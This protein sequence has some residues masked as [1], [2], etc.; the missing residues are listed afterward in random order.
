M[1]FMRLP[2]Q[3]G[4]LYVYLGLE[5]GRLFFPVRQRMTYEMGL[6]FPRSVSIALGKPESVTLLFVANGHIWG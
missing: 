6:P 3:T 1:M 4:E 5:C 2:R